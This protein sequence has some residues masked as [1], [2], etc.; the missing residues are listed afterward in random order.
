MSQALPRRAPG[1]PTTVSGMRSSASAGPSSASENAR[2]QSKSRLAHAWI[3]ERIADGRFSPGYRLVLG[4]IARDLEISP[5][6]VR[7][8][9]RLLE[10]EG[11]VTFEPNVGASVA[12]VDKREYLYTMQTLSLVE[13]SATAMSAPLLDA[14]ALHRAREANERMAASI[15]HFDPHHITELNRQF[16]AVL[17]EPCP[18]PHILDL[19]H[20]GWERLGRL[21]DSIFAFVPGRAPA[22][23]AEHEHILNLIEAG[24]PSLEIELAARDHRLTTLDAVLARQG[25]TE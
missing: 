2:V 19:V 23:V 4:Q 14:D 25:A 24:A 15:E 10:A 12:L 8:A 13:G 21:R 7:E 20:R 6:P 9:I 18:N 1:D 5:V 22:S 11:L 17:F 3:R 16:H